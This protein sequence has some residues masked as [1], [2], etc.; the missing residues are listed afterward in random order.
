MMTQ[1]ECPMDRVLKLVMGPWTTYILWILHSQGPQRFGALKKR[2]T[3]IS[4]K[5]LTQRLRMLEAG[6]LVYRDYVPTVPPRVSYGLTTRGAELR[7][8]LDALG[9]VA[10]RWMAEDEAAA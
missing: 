4:A 1:G 10:R 6:G 7:D 2:V 3:G 5:M 9:A 8:A